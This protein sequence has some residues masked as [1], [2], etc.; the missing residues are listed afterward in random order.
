MS[1]KMVQANGVELCVE[2]FGDRADP[3]LLLIMGSSASMDWWEDGFCE[4]LSAGPRFVVRYDQRDTG[5]SVS[6]EARLWSM[7]WIWAACTSSA[8]RWAAPSPRSRRSTTPDA[9]RPSR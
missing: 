3:P 2:T 5:R 1:S 6:Y 8:C 7:N 9:W 4:R